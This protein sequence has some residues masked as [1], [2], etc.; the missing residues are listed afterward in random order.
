MAGLLPTVIIL[1]GYVRLSSPD[2][3][4]DQCFLMAFY[5]TVYPLRYHPSHSNILLSLATYGHTGAPR[6]AGRWKWRGINA[7]A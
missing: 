5:V 3:F 6:S 4:L 1:A 7:A 2:P